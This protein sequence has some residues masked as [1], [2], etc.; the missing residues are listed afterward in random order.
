LIVEVPE[1]LKR[2]PVEL[3]I[4]EDHEFL[5]RGPVEDTDSW[6]ATKSYI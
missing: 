2:G 5:K 4:V 3:L 1:I 6:T